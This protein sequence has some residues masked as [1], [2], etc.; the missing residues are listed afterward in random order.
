MDQLDRLGEFYLGAEVSTE[1]MEK[2]GEPYLYASS[3]L[4]THAMIVGMTGSGK[5]GLGIDLLEEAVMDGLP[6]IV[7]DPKG[8]MSNLLLANP[9]M[10]TEWLFPY[11]HPTDGTSREEEAQKMAALWKEG[12]TASGFGPA[13]VALFQQAEK[14][15][16]TPGGRDGQPLSI[17]KDL[18]APSTSDPMERSERVAATVAGLLS[19]V[20]VDTDP[21][22]SRPSLLLSSILDRQWAA[23]N[24]LDM[25]GLIDL[26]QKPGID[27]LGV[28]PLAQVMPEKERLELAMRFNQVLASPQFALWR[29]GM[30]M[31]IDRLL[32]TAEGKPRVSIIQISHLSDPERM[33]VLTLLLEAL[34]DWMRRQPGQSALK[35]IFYM[36]E[37][38]GFFPPVENPPTKA[39]MLTLLKQ[40]RAFGLGLVLATQNPVD[41]DYRGLSNIGTW[42][43]GHLQTPQDRARLLDGLDTEGITTVEG[44]GREAVDQLLAQLAKRTFYVHNVHAKKPVLFTT[45]WAMSY[46]AGPLTGAQ[47]SA[48]QPAEAAAQEAAPNPPAMN[49]AAAANGGAVATEQET[50]LH[51]PVSAPQPSVAPE[52]PKDMVPYY[53]KAE[54]PA[55]Y[56]P[57]LLGITHLLFEEPKQDLAHSLK[58]AF[59]APVPEGALA[60]DWGL[61]EEVDVDQLALDEAVP[62]GATFQVWTPS[63]LT[64]TNR[65]AWARALKDKAYAEER[66]VLPYH[67][68]TGLMGQV[69]ER[70]EAFALRLD[71]ALRGMRDEKVRKI[72]EKYQKKI[73]TMEERIRKAD[74]TVERE[75]SQARAAKQSTLVSLGSTILGGLL[76][77]KIMSARNLGRV[78][79]TARSLSRQGAQTD[80]IRRAEENADQYRADLEALQADLAAELEAVSASFAAAHDQVETVEIRLKKTNI[81]VEDLILVWAP[82]KEGGRA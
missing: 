61:A 45:R 38:R 52:A 2:T 34:V 48:L 30:P 62:A 9:T 20:G 58:K 42:F 64:K 3:D 47:L 5:T 25:E 60:V 23:G 11:V 10:D 28:M 39:P 56:R 59:L 7:V 41:L 81:R 15:V 36:D 14:A 57:M 66:L 67:R 27:R 76:G 17:L 35:A 40:A 21:M 22:T 44:A 46:L 63:R 68:E 54:G 16:Y 6:A 24:A 4:T 74:L 43:I 82:E 33:F 37:I 18:A 32:Y 71:G 50:P 72:K 26:I 1:T 79:S 51:E 75:E 19:L 80:D 78:G 53:L 31:D 29:E 65:T 73:D 49:A 8:D 70:P 69:D 13:R 55:R 77:G 12:W